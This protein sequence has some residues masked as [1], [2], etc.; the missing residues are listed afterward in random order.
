MIQGL[1][2]KLPWPFTG[3]IASSPSSWGKPL[4]PFH[5]LTGVC[6]FPSGRRKTHQKIRWDLRS[7]RGQL[8]CPVEG[9]KLIIESRS[10]VQSFRQVWYIYSGLCN[11]NKRCRWYCSITP[12]ILSLHMAWFC[13]VNIIHALS[14]CGSVKPNSVVWHSPLKA[15]VAS[16]WARPWRKWGAP[17]HDVLHCLLISLANEDLWSN[18][19]IIDADEGRE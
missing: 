12:K 3:G 15:K 1:W 16:T 18:R 2:V 14:Q 9:L 17:N 10:R 13:T 7:P 4:Q 11:Y 19:S 8:R 5:Y 6:T